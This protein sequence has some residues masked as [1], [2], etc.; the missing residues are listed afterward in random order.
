M[1]PTDPYSITNNMHSVLNNYRVVLKM[2]ARKANYKQEGNGI[3]TGYLHH[4]EQTSPNHGQEADHTHHGKDLFPIRSSSS[5]RTRAAVSASPSSS[6]SGSSPI[7]PHGA[8]RSKARLA[9]VLRQ[10]AVKNRVCA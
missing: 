3:K 7:T 1:L 9:R 6:C 5:S 2:L 4:Q 8:F 10:R